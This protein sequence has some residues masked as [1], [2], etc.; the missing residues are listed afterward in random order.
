MSYVFG[1]NGPAESKT[2]LHDNTLNFQRVLKLAELGR[3]ND[4]Y[5]VLHEVIH[6]PGILCE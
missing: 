3:R 5:L 2:L 4:T 6:G 1:K